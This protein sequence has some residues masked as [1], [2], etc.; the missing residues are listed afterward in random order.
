MS[1]VF[2]GQ[3]LASTESATSGQSATS[4]CLSALPGR[5]GRG[6]FVLDGL[7]WKDKNQCSYYSYTT[8]AWW[9]STLRCN[10]QLEAERESTIGE[11]GGPVRKDQSPKNQKNPRKKIPNEEIDWV[12]VPSSP[13]SFRL[14]SPR[15]CLRKSPGD[16]ELDRKKVRLT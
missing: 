10:E 16:R 12:E 9:L 4:Q 7:G 13:I 14:P 11:E 15:R 8:T 6:K 2:C 3:A 5:L 1:A